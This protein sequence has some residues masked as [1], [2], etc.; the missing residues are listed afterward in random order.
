MNCGDCG[1]V[2]VEVPHYE[3]VTHEMAMDAQDMSL[4]GSQVVFGSEEVKEP[5]IYCNAAQSR[6]KDSI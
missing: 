6:P 3:T 1:Y 2:M 5:C 4:E